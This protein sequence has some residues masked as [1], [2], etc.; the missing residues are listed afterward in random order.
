MLR[1]SLNPSSV[2]S[3][4]PSLSIVGSAYGR[5]LCP[6]GI[7]G[8]SYANVI[9]MLFSLIPCLLDLYFCLFYLG[10]C[11][12]SLIFES[13]GFFQLFSKDC[14]LFPRSSQLIIGL[15]QA[16]SLILGLSLCTLQSRVSTFSGHA[17]R[18]PA[19]SS[20]LHCFAQQC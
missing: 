16:F 6:E 9:A 7:L 19:F 3:F 1:R 5:D 8:L 2:E 11:F 12:L 13:L 20:T 17:P 4:F 10:F 14:H 15:T 18:L